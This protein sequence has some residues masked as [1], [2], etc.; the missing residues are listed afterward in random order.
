MRVLRHAEAIVELTRASVVLR[1]V[2]PRSASALLGR[3]ED[4]PARA[5]SAAQLRD[6]RLIGMIV[7]SDA[8]R[9]PWKPSC[10]RQ[11]LAVQ[12]M[13]RRRDIPGRLH[14]G[15]APMGDAE[16]HAWVT[17]GSRTVIGAREQERFV[18]L[19]VFV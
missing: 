7:A 16:A 8:R 4:A 5:A 12:R 6:A 15:V 3:V 18:P 11:A 14:L 9:L 19:G 1:L 13:L 10:L 2:P 17:V